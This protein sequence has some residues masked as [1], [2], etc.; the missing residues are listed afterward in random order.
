MELNAQRAVDIGQASFKT[1]IDTAQED[2]AVAIRD[3]IHDA[4]MKV[5]ATPSD[6]FAG[7]MMYHL[8]ILAA[9]EGLD[10]EGR[11]SV[12]RGIRA[13]MTWAMARPVNAM[14]L[15]VDQLEMKEN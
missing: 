10:V 6:F 15:V 13:G 11:D 1:I 2:K 3:A 8:S 5:S 4:Y 9:L 7:V 14:D 12:I